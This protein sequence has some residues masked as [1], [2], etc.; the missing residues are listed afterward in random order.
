MRF[1]KVIGF[2][3]LLLAGA[4]AQTR[5]TAEELRTLEQKK[6]A[7]R[8]VKAIPWERSFDA[9]KK[10]ALVEGKLLFAYFTR[11]YAD[12][13]PCTALESSALESKA[14]GVFARRVVPFLHV[15]TRIPRKLDDD[16]LRRLKQ[17]ESFPTLLF[18]DSTG[19]VR[20]RQGLRMVSAFV[21]K[22]DLLE[23]CDRLKTA[24]R[25]SRA[26]EIELFLAQAE[27]GTMDLAAA[28][29]RR[30]TLGLLPPPEEK[31]W[32]QQLVNLEVM[33][34]LG[35]SGRSA[36]TCRAFIGMV[37]KKRLPSGYAAIQFWLNVMYYARGAGDK[38]YPALR[39]AM[40]VASVKEPALVPFLARFK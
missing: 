26:Q 31:R 11:S 17:I 18:I 32:R 38:R 34:I 4:D 9:A 40:R 24:K 10:R 28:K 5:L 20:A 35:K 14:F 33:D 6:L 2:T 30:A 39:D 37:E 1:F 29:T 12:C 15:T 8:F 22:L 19:A 16:L 23:E 13:P 3:L 27:I 7:S 36:A 21:R 25:R